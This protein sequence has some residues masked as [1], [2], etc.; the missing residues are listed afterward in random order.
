MKTTSTFPRVSIDGELIPPE[1]IEHEFNRLIQFYRGHLPEEQVRAQAQ[2]LGQRAIDQAIGAKLLL[3][4]ALQLDLPV[5]EADIDEQL[6][7][8]AEQLGGRQKFLAALKEQGTDE[9]GFRDQLRV[10]VKANK[11]IE[12]IGAG[13]DE[14]RED[15]IR[16]HFEEHKNEYQREAR[17]LAQHILVT[18]ANDTPQAKFDAIG[19]LNEIRARIEAGGD[20]AEEAAAHSDCPSGKEAGGSLGWFSRGM[21]VA[22]F[23]EAVFALKKEE[24]S[25]VVE[26]EFGYHLIY[27]N[28]EEA[29]KAAE[30]DDVRE[31]I[32]DFL[33]HVRRGEAVSAYVAELREKV[34]VEII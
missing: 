4:R 26:S 16:V 28:D 3:K 30:F 6:A 23:D 24:L 34:K 9:A 33:R 31:S 20:F 15:E 13:V 18:P 17:V 29:A 12:K 8:V 25:E 7:E 10:G 5:A 21:M 22:V 1:A 19:K 11:L 2:Q 32:R 14:P 27:K